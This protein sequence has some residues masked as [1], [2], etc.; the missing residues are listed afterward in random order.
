MDHLIL[1]GSLFG[2]ISIVEYIFLYRTYK[3][4]EERITKNMIKAIEKLEWQE[5][6]IG[7]KNE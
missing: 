2:I 3:K 7:D 6:N 5:K 1:I 4:T